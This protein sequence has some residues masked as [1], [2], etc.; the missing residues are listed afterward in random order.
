MEITGTI[1]RK[2]NIQ[3]GTS[4]KGEWQK[5]EFIIETDERYPKNVCITAWADKVDELNA[6]NIEDKVKLSVN[7]E[8]REF[9]ERWYTDIR[10]WKIERL[11]ESGQSSANTN[12]NPNSND[13]RNDVNVAAFESDQSD[14]DDLPF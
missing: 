14:S 1:K 6:Y 10:F 12:T 3:R 9:N 13:N 8:S 2:L 5:Q 4:A 11:Q 7:V